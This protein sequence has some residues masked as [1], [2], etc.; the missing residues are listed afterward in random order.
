MDESNDTE[1]CASQRSL[2]PRADPRAN[3]PAE[4][5]ECQQRHEGERGL[6][7]HCARSQR[8]R[9]EQRRSYCEESQNVDRGCDVDGGDEAPRLII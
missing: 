9:H 1:I 2:R 3:R 8:G 6:R 7:G 5:A 4:H